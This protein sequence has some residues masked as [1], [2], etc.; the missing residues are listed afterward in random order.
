MTLADSIL[1]QSTLAEPLRVTR[2]AESA[3]PVNPGEPATSCS[4]H[5][6]QLVE[7]IDCPKAREIVGTVF[8]DL[9]RLLEC[10]HPI[11]SR[12]HQVDEAEAEETF[13]LFQF[14]HDEACA[15]VKFISEDALTCEA[16]DEDLCDTLDGITFA[17]SHDLQRV[18]DNKLPGTTEEMT[19]R[20]V[21]GKLFRAHDVLT[22][23]LQQATISLATMFDP[24]LVGTKLFSNSDMC[25]RQSVQLCEDLSTLL[26]L[27]EACG[28]T[29]VEPAFA[30]LTAGI[31]KFRN[32]SMEC[33][34]YSDCPQFESFCERIQLAATP[35]DV[36]PVLHQFRCYVVTLLG[37]VKMRA[38]L[39]NVFPIEFGA[40][41]IQQ[42]PSPAQNSS[43][44]SYSP[45]D[46]QDDSVIRDTPAIAV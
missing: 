23:C 17:V 3:G 33:L 4:S 46:F 29:R 28:E 41:D 24:E 2:Q 1:N 8:E 26:K 35:P 39:A 43:T 10:L 36:E 14:I 5:L 44:Q 37:Q 6:N 12:L 45:I 11:E 34:R 38:V 9:L 42:L 22:N 30:N 18:F 25:Y 40:N 16:L 20:V 27:V 32:E 31:E 19:G 13:D 7:Q 21:V 15:L